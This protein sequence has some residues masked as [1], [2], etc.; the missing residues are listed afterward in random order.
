MNKNFQIEDGVL[1]T[2]SG[3]SVDMRG[4][5]ELLS[6]ELRPGLSPCVE[7]IWG[8]DLSNRRIQIVFE[9]VDDFIVKGRDTEYPVKS[10]AV[11]AIAGFSNRDDYSYDGEF[12]VEPTREMKYMSFVMDDTSA[13]LIKAESANMHRV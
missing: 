7:M 9:S 3:E 8:I 12:Y 1:F 11:L 5:C 4:E 2:F 10:G 6:V 13:F